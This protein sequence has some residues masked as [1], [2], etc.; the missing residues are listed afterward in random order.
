MTIPINIEKLITGYIVE[1][2]R[3]VHPYSRSDEGVNDGVKIA[4]T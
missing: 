1:S 2:K 4:T 3:I